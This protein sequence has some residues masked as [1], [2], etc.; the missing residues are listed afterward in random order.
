MGNVDFLQRLLAACESRQLPDDLAQWLATGV[1]GVLAGES[2][3]QALGL[4][5]R[6]GKWSEAPSHAYR[7]SE[8]DRLIRVIATGA[9]GSPYKRAE[10]VSS[11]VRAHPACQRGERTHPEAI[12]DG[13]KPLLDLLLEVDSNPPVSVGHIYRILTHRK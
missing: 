1:R 12:P 2:M 3:D 5:P 9:A 11:W 7:L 8:R 10:M 4:Q 6:P 13:L